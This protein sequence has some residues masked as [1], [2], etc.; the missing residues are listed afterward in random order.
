MMELRRIFPSKTSLH[1]QLLTGVSERTAE[2]WL[3]GDSEP[4]AQALVDL[5]RSEIGRE[6]LFA[7]LGETRPEWAAKYAKQLDVN[8]LRRRA[9]ELARIAEQQQDEVL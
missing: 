7:A 8:D 6:V 1:I 9:R 4:S 5:L 2:R 3:S